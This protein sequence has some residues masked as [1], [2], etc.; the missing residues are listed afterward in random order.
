MYRW[1]RILV[2]FAG[3]VLISSTVHAQGSI[4]GVIKDPS[5]AVLPGVTVEAAS[6]AL[7]E[8]VRL[9]VTDGTGQYRII[10]LR[11]GT[12]T[13]TFALAGSAPS[14]AKASAD[15]VVHGERQCGA[16][17]GQP[18]RDDHCDRRDADRG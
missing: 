14:G 7:I 2:A 10:D 6:D 17:G 3:T 11:A 16:A 4:T 13:I 15:R 12:Y 8:R 9:A 18:G 1:S 5:G